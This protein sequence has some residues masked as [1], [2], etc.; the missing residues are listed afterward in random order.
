MM[1][2]NEVNT[3]TG[4]GI[5]HTPESVV[6]GEQAGLLPLSASNC[7]GTKVDHLASVSDNTTSDGKSNSGWHDSKWQTVQNKRK[8]RDSPGNTQPNKR[9][10][11]LNDY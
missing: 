1:S 5:G 7:N 2:T 8:T 10:T 6:G 4:Q 3:V 11:N 9:Q